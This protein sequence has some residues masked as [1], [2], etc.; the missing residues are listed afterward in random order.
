M[1]GFPYTVV[2]KRLESFFQKIQQVGRPQKVDQKWLASVGFQAKND[3]QIPTV[4]KFI[5]L[6]DQS[7]TPTDKWMQF[8]GRNRA[9]AVL[10][11][12][13][14]DGYAELFQ[15]Y[16]NANELGETELKN[17]FGTKTSAGAH[18]ISRT[19]S[20]FRTL[21]KLADFGEVPAQ[22]SLPVA[23]VQQ[24]AA[25][26]EPATRS[27]V[28]TGA[29]MTININIQLTLPETKDQSVYDGL[30]AALKKHLLA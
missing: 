28:Q 10:A 1:A 11:E 16:H 14:R 27:T 7:G 13:I 19:V 8:R 6:I 26:S 17:F 30:F 2:P 21:C 25:M 9:G 20:T 5:G 18:T 24:T 23:G 4:L 15:T 22:A 3:R 29:G 12:G